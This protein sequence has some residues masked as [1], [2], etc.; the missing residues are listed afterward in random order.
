MSARSKMSAALVL[1]SLAS[2]AVLAACSPDASSDKVHAK[3]RLV[4]KTSQA[5]GIGPIRALVGNYGPYCQDD[6]GG[7]WQ[8]DLRPG[9]TQSRLSVLR[10][11][12]ACE[13]IVTTISVGTDGEN[14][15]YVAAP[16]FGLQPQ[17]ATPASAF[18][19]MPDSPIEFYATAR[20]SSASFDQDFVID[21]MYSD[22]LQTLN[23][24]ALAGHSVVT[25]TAGQ[26]GAK[27]APNYAVDLTGVDIQQNRYTRVTSRT[28]N[29]V[30]TAG[31]EEA[32]G[33]VVV[34]GDVDQTFAGIESA[35]N[36]GV[37]STPLPGVGAQ[38]LLPITSLL[39]V[40]DPVT[41][42]DNEA[43]VLGGGVIRSVIF[44]TESAE[45]VHSYQLVKLTFDR[46]P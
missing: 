8:L 15:G 28:G 40:D 24:S 2:T 1:L 4:D 43:T 21:V 10:N 6:P 29:V 9:G 31:T 30:F 41:P 12:L 17:Y 26:V 38:T 46:S 37:P 33:Y 16:Q 22:D 20:L 25:A 45:H 18:R 5:L 23:A 36:G 14:T 11:D 39:S 34:M 32:N 42:N 13:L 27:A 44:H 3:G 35:Y 19:L 7:Y